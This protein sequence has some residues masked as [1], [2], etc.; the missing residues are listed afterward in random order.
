MAPYPRVPLHASLAC[1][2]GGGL[3]TGPLQPTTHCIPDTHLQEVV[4]GDALIDLVRLL[5]G[6]STWGQ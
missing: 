5:G 1:L 3:P 6:Q 2:L 4:E